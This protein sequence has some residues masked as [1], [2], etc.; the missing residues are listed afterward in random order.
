ME[1]NKDIQRERIKEEIHYRIELIKLLAIFFLTLIGGE[2][3]LFLKGFTLKTLI[4]FIAG[5]VF[6]IF[7][8]LLLWLQHKKVLKLLNMLEERDD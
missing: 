7:L 1:E 5:V 4:L 2:I 8:G 6:G 3:S